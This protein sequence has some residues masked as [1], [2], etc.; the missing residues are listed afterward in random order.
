MILPNTRFLSKTR[1]GKACL[2]MGAVWLL[3]CGFMQNSEAMPLF[4]CL[5]IIYFGLSFFS[6]SFALAIVAISMLFSPEI[7]L[8]AIGDRALTLRIEDFL[9]PVMMLAWIARS[10]TQRGRAF[11]VATPLNKPIMALVLFSALSSAV[12]VTRGS[13]DLLP[14]IF[15]QG[16][17]IEYLALF[18]VV[19]NFIQTEKQVK[20]FLIFALVTV[21]LLKLYTL[22]QIPKTEVFTEHRITAPFEGRPEPS[23]AGGYL[24]FCFLLVF[25]ILIYQKSRVK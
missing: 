5:A 6:T 20:L 21:A 8:G 9:I 1:H 2:V 3:H 23:T 18:Y 7:S 25:S 13:V 17:V 15:F 19:L 11:F 24:A 4:A 14:T 12:G 10:A 22:P 16:K